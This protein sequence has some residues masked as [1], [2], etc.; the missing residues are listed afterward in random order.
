MKTDSNFHMYVLAC[1]H[2]LPTPEDLSLIP[3]NHMLEGKNLSLEL[4]L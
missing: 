4:V 3:G 1:V 2:L